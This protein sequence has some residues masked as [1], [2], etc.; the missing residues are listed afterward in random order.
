[1]NK[2]DRI[3][4]VRKLDLNTE[5]SILITGP[6]DLTRIMDFIV[7]K[8]HVSVRSFNPSDDRV[9]APHFPLISVADLREALQLLFS[10][11]FYAILAD[12]ID[13]NDAELA[14]TIWRQETNWHVE[15]ANGPGTTRMV[16]HDN[17]IDYMYDYP[18]EDIKDERII[19][20]INTLIPVKYMNCLY[21][22]SYYRIPVGW[23]HQNIIIWEITGDGTKFA[24]K[25]I[26]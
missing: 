8:D 22:I 26:L 7:K 17:K 10:A 15:L 18:N 13:P 25:P 6:L 11:G 23:K 3:Q 19:A 1:L 2:W 14:G 24:M 9:K 20:M 12:P 4:L 21:E 5:N 16:T